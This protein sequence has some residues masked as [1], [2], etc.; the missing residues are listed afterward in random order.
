L[1]VRGI[2]TDAAALYPEPIAQVF[3]AVPHQI[4]EFHVIKELTKA[5][6]RTVAKVRKQ[7]AGQ[8]PSLPRGRPSS[9]DDRL[10]PSTSNAVERDNRRYR[11]MQ[12]TVYRVRSQE[13]ISNRIALDMLREARK[14]QPPRS[15]GRINPGSDATVSKKAM[16]YLRVTLSDSRVLQGTGFFGAEP[17]LVLTNAHVLGMLRANGRPPTKIDVVLNCGETGEKILPG[18]LVGVDQASDLALLCLTAKDLPEPLK[19]APAKDLQETEGVFIFGFP[20]G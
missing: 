10:L 8:K 20:F 11:K 9:R 2:T 13:H 14:L 18:Q 7:L 19:V 17:G 12:K 5:V 16:V 15:E 3:G 6:L 1:A 4:C